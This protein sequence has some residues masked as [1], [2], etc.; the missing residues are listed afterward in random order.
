MTKKKLINPIQL[1]GIIDESLET[2]SDKTTINIVDNEPVDN[3]IV[4]F[5]MSKFLEDGDEIY[6][7]EVIETT[8]VS[9][10]SK[11]KKPKTK[12][13]D[14]K[15]VVVADENDSDHNSPGGLKHFQ[16]DVPYQD[17]YNDSMMDLTTTIGQLN[18]LAVSVRSDLEQLRDS[19]TVR[20]RHK[21]ISEMSSAMASILSTKVGAI[22]ERNNIISKS[23]DLEL[24]RIKDLNL[25]A[26]DEVDHDKA[27]MDTYTSFITMPYG[28]GA[29]VQQYMPPSINSITDP[30]NISGLVPV[31]VGN[32][33]EGFEN[34]QK[35]LTPVQNR[36][37]YEDNPDVKTVVLYNRDTGERAFDIRNIRTGESMPNIQRPHS[38]FLEDT[39]IDVNKG[40]ARNANIDQTYPV[41]EI[42]NNTLNKY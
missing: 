32:T 39:T 35:N 23:H 36:M 19:K 18:E 42:S 38:M 5:S 7:E 27:L 31:D 33:D 1:V 26:I 6:V 3:S 8:P 21:N 22:R 25:N 30:S 10:K 2:P 40:I 34:Y 29:N 13:I 11:K 41:I 14:G 9:S 20:G 16:T 17:T 12:K 15:D 37:R 4:D 28:S 24:K